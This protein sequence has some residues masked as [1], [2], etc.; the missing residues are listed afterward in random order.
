MAQQFKSV[1]LYGKNLIPIE[2]LQ[3]MGA[4]A[5]ASCIPTPLLIEDT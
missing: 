2:K 1:D 4:W 5:L 3:N